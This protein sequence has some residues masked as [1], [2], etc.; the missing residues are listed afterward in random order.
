MNS[1]QLIVKQQLEIETLKETNN[2][3]KKVLKNIVFSCYAI[4]WPLNDNVLLF[5]KEQRVFIRGIADTAAA[6]YE[7]DEDN[8]I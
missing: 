7:S 4:W 3:M 1:E 8:D 2:D 6:T 5:S